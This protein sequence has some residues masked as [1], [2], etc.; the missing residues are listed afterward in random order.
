MTFVDVEWT[1]MQCSGTLHIYRYDSES[2]TELGSFYYTH[3]GGGGAPATNNGVAVAGPVYGSSNSID[4]L[5]L[6]G[7][8]SC[9]LPGSRPITPGFPTASAAA[10]G[11]PQVCGV[12]QIIL[13][14]L[15]LTLIIVSRTGC[16]S[17]VSHDLTINATLS[18]KF[19]IAY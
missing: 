18:A 9:S 11:V 15:T 12:S 6:M 3:G 14:I 16:R 4:H 7:A 19:A 13:P 5:H 17:L 8:A 1:T 10:G 2:E